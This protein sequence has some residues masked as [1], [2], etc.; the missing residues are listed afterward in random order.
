MAVPSAPSRPPVVA[1]R[2]PSFEAPIAAIGPELLPRDPFPPQFLEPGEAVL[3]SVQ[4]RVR[5]FLGIPA[6][7]AAAISLLALAT[8]GWLAERGDAAASPAFV[9]FVLAFFAATGLWSRRLGRGALV[10]LPLGYFFGLIVAAFAG[11]VGVTASNGASGGGVTAT[12]AVVNAE[13][14]L[15]VLL[16]IAIPFPLSLLAWY[17]TSYALTDRRVIEVGGV[18]SRGSRWVPLERLGPIAAHQSLA[19]R[20]IG[21]GR[22][23]F[24]DRHPPLGSGRHFFGPRLGRGTVGAEFYGITDPQKLADR[25]EPIVAPARRPDPPPEGGSGTA[26][27][28]VGPTP[29]PPTAASPTPVPSPTASPGARCPRCGTALIYVAPASR[30]YCPVCGRY[31]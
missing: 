6:L 27:P 24:V 4:P 22:L 31:T 17:R 11:P 1:V 29:T 19:G 13:V 14:A 18:F 12:A 26:P 10:L 2:S 7:G 20:R 23:R 21:Y 5:A 8:S 9:L 30:F 15:F 25:L 28:G 16:E 3:A